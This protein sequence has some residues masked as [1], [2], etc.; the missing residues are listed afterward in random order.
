MSWYANISADYWRSL[1]ISL[2]V[3]GLTAT[4]VCL[5]GVPA[6]FALVRGSYPGRNF[7]HALLM[8]PLQVPF[9]VSGIVFMQFYFFLRQIIGLSLLGSITGLTICHVILGL[10]FMV[11][12]LGP[13]LQRFHVSLEEAALS[14]G[15]NRVGTMRRVTLPVIAPG[16]VGGAMYAFISSFGDVAATVFLVSTK[17]MTL[18]VEM[19]YAMEFDMNPS[20]LAI[21]TIVIILS[22]A[23]V[24]LIY[25]FTGAEGK[26]G[27]QRLG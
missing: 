23:F 4:C 11:G 15:A 16:I 10:P 3:A 20:V 18:P 24:S 13:V 8:S 17:T 9:V 19:F 5:L 27:A 12:T 7:V 14:L 26:G 21:S 1:G 25:R 2:L 6:T 22:A